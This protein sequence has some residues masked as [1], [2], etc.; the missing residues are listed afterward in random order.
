MAG[1]A[2]LV[3]FLLFAL[4]APLVLYVLVRDETRDNP[5]MRREDAERA[6]RRDTRDAPERAG[7]G[8]HGDGDGC[9]GR[10]D[11]DGHDGRW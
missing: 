8:V 3:V 10:D 11:H 9:D 5:V 1:E 7:R 4:A 6:V 2:L